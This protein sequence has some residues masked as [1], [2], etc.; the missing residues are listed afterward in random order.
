MGN[1]AAS[2]E[3]FKLAAESARDHGLVHEQGL[4]YELYGDFL[5]SFADLDALQWHQR[6]HTCYLQWGALAKAEQLRKEFN[7][8]LR[9]SFSS[10]FNSS[11]SS[12]KHSR[13]EGE[14]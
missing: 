5:F 7:L 11:L 9:E 1:I 8:E 13:D 14:G 6:A 10:S 12:T 2:E 4:A 3:S